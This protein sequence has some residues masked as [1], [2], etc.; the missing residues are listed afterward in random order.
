MSKFRNIVLPATTTPS[1]PKDGQIY[2]DSTLNQIRVYIDGSWISLGTGTPGENGTNGKEIEL[3]KNSTHLQWRYVG[4]SS[5]INLIELS[6]LIPTT[7]D[8]FNITTDSTHR[9][10]TDSE[11][12]T[13]NGKQDSLGFTPENSANK[14]IANGYVPLDSST[15]IASVY[16]PSYVDDVQ[17][18]SSFSAF[19]SGE[20]GKIYVDLNVNK[21]YRWSMI[22]SWV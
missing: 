17:E 19:P 10:T 5:W 9:F 21:I 11:K 20:T 1:S 4:D 16:L 22:L 6:Q 8:A 3:Q 2:H 13:W 18:Y 15:K 12:S 14:G 7:L